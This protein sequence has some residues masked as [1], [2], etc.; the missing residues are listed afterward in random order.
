MDRRGRESSTNM[1]I[2]RLPLSLLSVLC[3][4][5]FTGCAASSGPT[6]D[7]DGPRG[8]LQD[9]GVGSLNSPTTSPSSSGLSGGTVGSAPNTE[10]GGP[11]SAGIPIGSVGVRH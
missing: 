2:S 3:A 6:V 11:V 7:A 1:Q 10:T 5:L 4:G 8:A 9:P